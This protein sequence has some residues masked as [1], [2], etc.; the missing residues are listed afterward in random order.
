MLTTTFHNETVPNGV[1]V[2]YAESGHDNAP[3]LLLLHGFPSTNLQFRNLI[4]LLAAS[5]HIIAPDLPGFGHTVVPEGAVPSFALMA[6]TISQLVDALRI[7]KFA[8]YVFDYG[9]PTLFRL[10]LQ[11]PELIAAIVTQNGNAY[12]EGLG[13]AFWSGL[14]AW[15][16][17]EEE[18]G[19]QRDALFAAIG[20]IAWTRAQYYDGVPEAKRALVDPQMPTLDYLQHL[21][22]PGARDTQLRIFWDYRHNVALYPRFQEYLRTHAPPLL[23]VWGENDPCFVFSGALAFKRD[24]PAADVQLLDGGHFL[25]ETHVRE[26][27]GLMRE[28]IGRIKW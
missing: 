5:Y 14:R 27:A 19:P 16:A 12:E 6:E 26:V 20:D 2:H 28:F 18:Y 7:S 9:A 22:A 11:R 15:W 24:V 8:V 13:E 4:P 23:A 3:V 21:A 25:L 1:N 10:A 17:G